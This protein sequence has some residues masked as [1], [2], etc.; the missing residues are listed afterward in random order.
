MNNIV[1]SKCFF[2]VFLCL[3]LFK[4]S[5]SAEFYI[6][7]SGDDNNPGTR[8]HPFER[9]ER[10]I[11]AVEEFYT[12][13]AAENCTIW[14][15][16]GKH[17]L[18]E[19]LVLNSSTLN[20]TG[21]SLVFKALPG[22]KPVISGGVSLSGWKKN[23]EGLWEVRLPEMHSA[24]VNPRELF[25]NSRPAVRARFPSSGY[26]RVK[27]A[28]ADRRT[29]FFFNEGD[30]PIPEKV[31]HTELVLL[32][33]WSISR[34]PVSEIDVSDSR[35]TTVDSIGAKN[36]AFFNLDHWEPNP[37]YFL[38]ND[39]EFL[40]A[41]Y[42]W[43]FDRE[44]KTFYLKLPEGVNPEHIEITVPVSE[45]LVFMKGSKDR[46]LTNI[47]FQGITFEHSSWEIPQSGY[48]G[49]QACHYD[50]R[51]KK[52][53]WA[54]VPAAVY[55]EWAENCSFDGCTFQKL[56]GSGL[57]LGTGCTNSVVSN[58]LFTNISGNGIMIGEGRDREINGEKWWKAAPSQAAQ[59]NT[60]QNCVVKSCGRQFYGAV[61]IWC[62]LTA[63]TTI[64]NNE[65]TDLPY[66]G[67]SVGWMWSPEPTPCR[68]NAIEGNHIHHIM[69]ELSDG[70]GIYML[71][72][73][74]GST[75]SGNRIHDVSLNVGRAESNGMFLDE[76][77]TDVVVS[78]NL[79]Y[80]IAK[81]PLR[82]HKATV[83]LVENNYLF[84]EDKN[85][86]VRYNNTKEQDIKKVDNKVFLEADED[87]ESELLKAI[88]EWNKSFR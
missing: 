75:I 22:A 39:M 27:K 26:L 10:A 64:R 72:L 77:T 24:R 7:P 87:Y 34:I 13:H 16:N 85:P 4:S 62:G 23:P 57:W 51:P 70:G 40:D 21:G 61:G 45:G 47:H 44:K 53:G 2:V 52:E 3:S 88:E 38:E 46:R 56:G 35:L 33:D 6:S 68:N 80:A 37:R 29:H 78:D 74:P 11:Q 66:S 41:D 48:C 15:D 82:F 59:A 25:V 63:E 79:I 69:Q 65:I 76:G 28:G 9:L 84:C 31:K 71:G 49:V 50:P 60:I 36:P 5:G 8:Q 81:S 43:Y 14:L 19:P 18:Y 55:A 67:I 54:V 73:Q 20:N 42:E 17:N 83:N 1:L 86:P 30:F 12:E 58:S 32:H